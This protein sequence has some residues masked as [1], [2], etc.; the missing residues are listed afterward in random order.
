MPCLG[1]CFRHV[2]CCSNVDYFNN[3]GFLAMASVRSC[4]SAAVAMSF[5]RLSGHGCCRS[6]VVLS[7]ISAA[8]PCRL[9][10]PYRLCGWR[11]TADM[12]SC[13]PGRPALL[14]ERDL[15]DDHLTIETGIS[16]HQ[17]QIHI[18]LRC[19]CSWRRIRLISMAQ[20]IVWV[21]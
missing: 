16:S 3:V 12:F 20:T 21:S 19:E 5:C 15:A 1:G 4:L 11:Q 17:N 13:F 14:R 6:N 2:G 7:A 8:R 9:F 10:R 18:V